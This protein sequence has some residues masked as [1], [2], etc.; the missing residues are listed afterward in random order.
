MLKNCIFENCLAH[1]SIMQ[2]LS[3]T[4]GYK[5]LSVFTT[6]IAILFTLMYCVP[7]EDLQEP[8]ILNLEIN[9]TYNISYTLIVET[10]IID[11]FGIGF[12]QIAGFKWVKNVALHFPSNH[13]IC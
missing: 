11:N 10:V 2:I 12:I 7:I 5:K 4:T 1:L 9:E 3:Y 13:T 6:I 8:Q